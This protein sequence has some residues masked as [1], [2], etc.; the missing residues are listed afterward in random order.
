MK[1]IVT[2][3]DRDHAI[4]GRLQFGLGPRPDR[5]RM[6]GLIELARIAIVQHAENTLYDNFP[7]LAD[8]HSRL[9]D[10]AAQVPVYNFDPGVVVTEIGRL[11]A[12]VPP[13][14]EH[15]DA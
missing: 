14:T 6:T 8:A 4:R 13:S 2:T 9:V 3:G 15:A 11:L 12:S 7:D 1:D 10:L 5:D